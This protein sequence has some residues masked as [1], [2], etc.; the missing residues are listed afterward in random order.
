MHALRDSLLQQEVQ[1]NARRHAVLEVPGVMET[2][3]VVC[4]A[5]AAGKLHG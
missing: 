2:G 3:G 4:E 1:R 5:A